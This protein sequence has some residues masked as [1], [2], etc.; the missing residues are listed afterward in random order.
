MSFRYSSRSYERHYS[1]SRSN[2]EDDD[3]GKERSGKEKA[4]SFRP[5]LPGVKQS[6]TKKERRSTRPRIAPA[7][8][9]CCI[10]TRIHNK[11]T[12]SRAHG[13]SG[14]RAPERCAR[15]KPVKTWRLAR[16][17]RKKKIESIDPVSSL[18]SRALRLTMFARHFAGSGNVS[19]MRL[20]DDGF[21]R[22]RG[23][24]GRN[25]EFNKKKKKKKSATPASFYAS[26]K[27][28]AVTRRWRDR[29]CPSESNKFPRTYAS[30]AGRSPCKIIH[31]KLADAK[32]AARSQKKKDPQLESRSAAVN[33]AH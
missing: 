23:S 16:V 22:R 31:V 15:A 17:G 3:R 26:A 5:S 19:V 29:A 7:P 30:D 25:G 33:T 20:V 10:A 6:S 11:R 32:L 9:R 24:R 27:R 21:L 1:T 13:P 14:M 28:R 12:W 18:R 4:I 2:R 8:G